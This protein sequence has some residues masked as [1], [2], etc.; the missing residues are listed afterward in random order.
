MPTED[1]TRFVFSL[2]VGHGDARVEGNEA[3]PNCGPK[4][5]QCCGLQHHV[6]SL[7]RWPP[8]LLRYGKTRQKI[9][10]V[11]PNNETQ[12]IALS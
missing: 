11:T 10:H 2:V 7:L 4:M 6:G 12:T 9:T 5:E 1:F 3:A 8:H